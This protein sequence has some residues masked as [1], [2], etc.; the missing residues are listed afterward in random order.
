[1]SKEN[2]G[3]TLDDIAKSADEAMTFTAVLSKPPGGTY[4]VS[5]GSTQNEKQHVV[6]GIKDVKAARE[7]GAIALLVNDVITKIGTS[8]LEDASRFNHAQVC[9]CV[10]ERERECVCV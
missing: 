8:T 6:H 3:K 2:R 7:S 5:I 4:G 9:V 1:M 10:R